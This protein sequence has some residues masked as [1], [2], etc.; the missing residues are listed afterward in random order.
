MNQSDVGTQDFTFGAG[1]VLLM[2]A[3]AVVLLIAT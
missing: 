1:G 2:V 3:V